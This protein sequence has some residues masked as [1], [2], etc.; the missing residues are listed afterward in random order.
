MSPYKNNQA[1]ARAPRH[2]SNTTR[3]Q[4]SN[5]FVIT[6][7]RLVYLAVRM[8]DDAYSLKYSNSIITNFLAGISQLKIG[9]G[10]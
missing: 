8:E 5:S 6:M 10:L 1:P 3:E 2:N 4:N 9:G 7:K